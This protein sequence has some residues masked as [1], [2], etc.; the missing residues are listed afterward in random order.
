M[1]IHN[2]MCYILLRSQ[3]PAMSLLLLSPFLDFTSFF[4]P[5][6]NF[7]AKCGDVELRRTESVNSRHLLQDIIY[8]NVKISIF[9]FLIFFLL[10][11]ND[12]NFHSS[13]AIYLPYLQNVSENDYSLCLEKNI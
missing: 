3:T 5:E 12:S 6:N 10:L 4:S 9:V 1:P 2:V 13:T 11:W 8:S 7:R